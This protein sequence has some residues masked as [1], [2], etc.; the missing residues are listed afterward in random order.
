MEVSDG[1]AMDAKMQ[2]QR[3]K[4]TGSMSEMRSCSRI[5]MLVVPEDSSYILA[6]RLLYCA[7]GLVSGSPGGTRVWR[8]TLVV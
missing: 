4:G 1:R 7:F 2:G 8:M 5:D 3:L 6:H